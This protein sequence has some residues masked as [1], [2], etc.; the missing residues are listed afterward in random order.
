VGHRTRT[1]GGDTVER[2]NATAAVIMTVLAAIPIAAAPISVVP[3]RWTPGQIEVQVSVN[4]STPEW[5]IVDTG[6]EYSI[7]DDSLARRLGLRTS[8]RLGRRFASGVSL[9]LGNVELRNQD[10]MVFALENFRRQKR[11]IA[12]VV[13]HDLFARYVV[14]IDYA[15]RTLTLHEPGS[16]R[17]TPGLHSIP[18]EFVGRLATVP[19]SLAITDHDSIPARVILDTGAA[20]TLILRHPYAESHHLLQRATATT[21]AGSLET[22]TV[23]FARLPVARLT[24]GGFSFAHPTLRMYMTAAGAGGDTETDGALGNEVLRR[25]VATFDYSRSR[26]HLRPNESIRDPLP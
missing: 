26:L 21:R 14:E 3:F 5:F 2:V 22:E 4:R 15:A 16:W 12:G 19:V 7:L 23:T 9:R 13:G 10:L 20:Q 24:L 6:A 17:A 1:T 11:A 25:F 18:I 8:P